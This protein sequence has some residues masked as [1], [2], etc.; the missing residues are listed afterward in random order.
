MSDFNFHVL[1][2]E[3]IGPGIKQTGIDLGRYGITGELE[4]LYKFRTP[5]L[6]N[7][8]LTAS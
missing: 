5:P 8:T 6:R 7:V 3:Q 2:V 1:G 4:D